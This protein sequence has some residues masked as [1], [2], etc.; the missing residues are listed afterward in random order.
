MSA[1]GT[2]FSASR[3]IVGVEAGGTGFKVAVARGSG[4]GNDILQV[5]T[6]ETTT[7]EATIAACAAFIDQQILERGPIASIGI[8]SFG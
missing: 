8:A 5:F 6:V 2:I 1:D 4:S 3:L 7:P